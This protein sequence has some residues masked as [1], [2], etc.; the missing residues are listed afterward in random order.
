LS[1]LV[2]TLFCLAAL[3]CLW[4]AEAAAGSAQAA[5]KD[6]YER[7]TAAYYAGRYPEA[8]A[9]FRKTYDLDPEPILL[10]NIAQAYRKLGNVEEALAHYRR[11]LDRAPQ[12][13][14]RET[15]RARI[16]ELEAELKDG[17]A[18]PSGQSPE[19]QASEPTAPPPT[20]TGAAA[21]PDARAP[22]VGIGTGIRFPSYAGA[23]LKNS[24]AVAVVSLDAGYRFRVGAAHLSLGLKGMFSPVF[25][26]TFT[27]KDETV[28]LLAAY[29]RFSGQHAIT[30]PLGLSWET[31]LGAIRWGELVAGNPFSN[32]RPTNGELMVSGFVGLGPQIR[33]SR[34]VA[35][36]LIVR[37][38][39]GRPTGALAFDWLSAVDISAGLGYAF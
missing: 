9:E 28:S 30:G 2:P 32:S 12:A 37:A 5:A 20:A 15:V 4:R 31:G 11:Y 24:P 29:A 18:S 6:H 23:P 38:V 21:P 22:A 17:S 26:Q 1:R 16:R 10:F 36:S 25:Y 35:A 3:V 8:I 34:A 14:N 39:L 13:D 33:L 27:K 7:A 19:P